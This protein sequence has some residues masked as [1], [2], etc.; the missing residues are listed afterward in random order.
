MAETGSGKT[1]AFLIPLLVWIQSLPK[2]VRLENDESGPYAII[3]APTREL[4]Q[5]MEEES[6]KNGQ[7]LDIRMVAVGCR[8]L[9]EFFIGVRTARAECIVDTYLELSKTNDHFSSVSNFVFCVKVGVI[10]FLF[11]N[12]KRFAT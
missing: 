4:A 11:N 2:N 3:L 6:I 10:I 12:L 9:G 7:Q 5:Q 8:S 1:A